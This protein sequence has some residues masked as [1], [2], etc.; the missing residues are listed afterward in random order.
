MNRGHSV[1]D[2]LGS[3]AAK[4]RQHKCLLKEHVDGPHTVVLAFEVEDTG[5]GVPPELREKIFQDFV[6]G[7]ASTTRRHGGTGL[8]L[9]I[10]RSL[11]RRMGGSIAVKEK[12]GTGA[13][14]RFTVQLAGDP[15]D[16]SG[17]SNMHEF[18]T[19]L[20]AARSTSSLKNT[21]MILVIPDS[22]VRRS[23]LSWM[24]RNQ[25][26]VD[27]INTWE[28]LLDLA[29]G[30]DGQKKGKRK[31]A[32]AGA[33]SS[34]GGRVIPASIN[35]IMA[36]STTCC[37]QLDA[38]SCGCASCGISDCHPTDHTT[39]QNTEQKQQAK[40]I[41]IIVD[42][43]L[44]PNTE[45]FQVEDLKEFIKLLSA[46]AAQGRLLG[47]DDA[48][49]VSRLRNSYSIS[50]LPIEK[51]INQEMG[52]GDTTTITTS[53]EEKVGGK[54]CIIR[55][56]DVT[57]RTEIAVF[58]ISRNSY[59]LIPHGGDDLETG[60]GSA[61]TGER[62]ENSDGPVEGNKENVDFSSVWNQTGEEDVEEVCPSG[63]EES[64]SGS[65][66]SSS[67]SVCLV[68]LIPV[69]ARSE[70]RWK[71]RKLGKWATSRELEFP[72]RS[73]IINKPFHPSRMLEILEM[74]ANIESPVVDVMLQGNNIS[75][76]DVGD[77]ASNSTE[78]GVL[79]M[80]AN[81]NVDPGG[82]Q[83]HIYLSS[84]QEDKQQRDP[85][86]PGESGL[87]PSSMSSSM[88]PRTLTWSEELS[89]LR[90]PCP[91]S[92]LGT[93]SGSRGWGWNTAT[94]QSGGSSP[95]QKSEV[96]MI[97]DESGSKRD[98][99]WKRL[100]PLLSAPSEATKDSREETARSAIGTSILSTVRSLSLT[101]PVEGTSD[102]DPIKQRPDGGSVC[103]QPAGSLCTAVNSNVSPNETALVDC[104]S[105]VQGLENDV[106][107]SP[108]PEGADV[109]RDQN[110][111]NTRDKKS[112]F[113]GGLEKPRQ[114]F[115][116]PGRKE[117]GGWKSGKS[118]DTDPRA[119]TG[120]ETGMQTRN[121]FAQ[122]DPTPGRI[123]VR[124]SVEA[125][126]VNGDK[127]W[128]MG[129]SD[130]IL[131]KATA[132]LG[133]EQTSALQR[134]DS[135]NNQVTGTRLGMEK[136]EG[137]RAS[138]LRV[139]VPAVTL[140]E[141]TI[142]RIAEEQHPG[143][144]SNTP[145]P[146]QDTYGKATVSHSASDEYDEAGDGKM[147]ARRDGSP[148][149]S[150]TKSNHGS[151]PSLTTHVS[152]GSGS[153]YESCF[154]PETQASSGLHSACGLPGVEQVDSDCVTRSQRQPEPMP[155]PEQGPD[156]I[157]TFLASAHTEDSK[158]S[159]SC[160]TVIPDNVRA[161]VDS[162]PSEDPTMKLAV[163]KPAATGKPLSG[164]EVLVAEDTALLR[165]LE[166]TILQRLGAKA[167]GVEDGKRAVDA[168]RERATSA[169]LK[170]FDCILMDCQMPV[171]DGYSATRAIREME[172]ENPGKHSHLP[173]IALTAH[174]MAHDKAKC[175]DAGMD[176]YLMKPMRVDQVLGVVKEF[177]FGRD[178]SASQ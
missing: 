90:F 146:E 171:M 110:P 137:E 28:T 100:I 114:A 3:H 35:D 47:K 76:D 51:K 125:A 93:A 53:E 69:T 77:V 119:L 54:E 71:L 48:A 130:L 135:D 32:D 41:F 36:P 74:A 59:A 43:N 66:Q 155:L 67:Q 72:V 14:F 169:T 20:M 44:V 140:T 50:T 139:E 7:D 26:K 17:C 88:P 12:L 172:Q 42:I 58:G 174:T 151:Q 60:K 6:Q 143:S 96:R 147:V 8:G 91:I 46:Q 142:G 95:C 92:P 170:Q 145:C 18:T 175:L 29:S 173:I 131:G 75:N 15:C 150:G 157:G 80:P 132:Q 22:L 81:P 4:D 61:E 153:S 62:C 94:Y 158:A 73:R 89:P 121:V 160:S 19:R 124:Q 166:L 118:K 163:Q 27:L 83:D 87:R 39:N 113:T 154:S 70:L 103:A 23:T 162:R 38:N 111:H 10:A 107:D 5:P 177:C 176:A 123:L 21:R 152:P 37:T 116:I 86:R 109:Y 104:Q 63:N 33:T 52:Q 144:I 98:H 45:D 165:K 85:P 112:I 128:H 13:L 25:V 16:S 101:R 2:L 168:V 64:D 159:A 99:G 84:L 161:P 167:V 78:D 79:M 105:L 126:C 164:M 56:L 82:T 31:V 55:V 11:A 129:S 65:V 108:N 133:V 1:L 40:Q 138:I 97:S 102:T 106:F 136:M 9:Y 134:T 30:R 117:G 120:S 127:T 24:T 122:P 149:R 156:G 141:G 68:W 34:E 148:V 49:S 115:V 178:A 57:P